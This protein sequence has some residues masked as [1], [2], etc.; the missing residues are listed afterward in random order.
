MDMD[1]NKN[2]KRIAEALK[3]PVYL[4]APINTKCIKCGRACTCYDSDLICGYYVYN[5]PN[6]GEYGSFEAPSAHSILDQIF[7]KIFK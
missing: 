5:C 4:F 6:C 3:T 2:S 1:I 7:K